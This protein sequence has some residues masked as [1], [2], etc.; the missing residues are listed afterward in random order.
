MQLNLISEESKQ[1]KGPGFWKFN[2][3]LL[4]DNRYISRLRENL[5]QFKSKYQNVEDLGLS[6]DLI[7]MEIRGFTVKYTKI[8]ARER[9]D[10]EKFLQNRINDLIAKTEKNKK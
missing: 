1:K 5:P 10:E 3:S 2:Y 6:W 7:K 4:K 8:K 9:R